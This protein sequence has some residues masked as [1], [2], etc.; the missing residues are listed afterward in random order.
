MRRLSGRHREQARSHRYSAVLVGAGLLAKGVNSVNL[1]K[2]D[3]YTNTCRVLAMY[4]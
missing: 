1:R 4:S 2:R 3:R